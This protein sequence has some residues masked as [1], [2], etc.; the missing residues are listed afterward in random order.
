MPPAELTV[1]PW[2][3]AG[4]HPESGKNQASIVI[5]THGRQSAVAW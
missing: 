1:A 3:L 5:G 2:A 4:D